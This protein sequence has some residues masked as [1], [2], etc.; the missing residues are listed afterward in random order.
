M[1]RRRELD[2]LRGIAILLVLLRHQPL[3]AWSTRMG[4]IGVDL[5]FVLSG[6]LVSG[7][8]FQEY[9]KFGDIKPARFLIRRGFKIYPIYYIT[10]P[11]YLLFIYVSGRPRD[12]YRAL[13]DLTFTQNY[14]FGWGYAYAASW[15]LAVEEHFYIILSLVLWW[16]IKYKKIRL[17]AS[18]N[19][20][21]LT[22]FQI[23]LISI[24]GICFFLRLFNNYFYPA[25]LPMNLT[26]THL[27]IDSLL[28]GVFISYLYYFR[29]E[30]FKTLFHSNR[31]LLYALCF[32]G[33]IWTP[34]IEPLESFFARVY[35]VAF[36]YSSF[37]ILLTIFLL[38]DEINE[39]LNKIFSN[40]I[41]N[42]ISKIGYCSYSIYIIHS[43][44]ILLQNR[45]IAQYNYYDNVY[46]NF[47]VAATLSIIIGIAMTY[48]I[49]KYF[50]ELRNRYF[51][52][53]AISNIPDRV[54]AKI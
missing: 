24:M 22:N 35:G 42:L 13:A 36:L 53:K 18:D 14:T 32:L 51:P 23:F 33:L 15:S 45:F 20:N 31:Y 21:G 50:L 43:L 19:E 37:G 2:F 1:K 34:F 11:L 52:S 27:R 12:K 16:S 44:I 10:Y 25:Y 9:L 4:W 49:E 28:A 40:R 17:T 8:L 38:T 39:K 3:F 7:L 30:Y 26:M 41:M 47:I 5:F 48:T 29:L 6:F 46:V 54:F